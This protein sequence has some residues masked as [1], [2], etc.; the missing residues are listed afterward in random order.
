MSVG[1]VHPQVLF[2]AARAHQEVSREEPLFFIYGKE[3]EDRLVCAK[4]NGNVLNVRN[5]ENEFEPKPQTK[6]IKLPPGL[7]IRSFIR[8]PEHAG[9]VVV[10]NG[11]PLLLRPRKYYLE[12]YKEKVS[13]PEYA[14]IPDD[15]E[16]STSVFFPSLPGIPLQE[17]PELPFRRL[18]PGEKPPNYLEGEEP[19]YEEC[20]PLDPLEKQ[21]DSLE[22]QGTIRRK[23]VEPIEPITVR[24]GDLLHTTV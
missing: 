20:T 13:E 4:V 19:F 21:V 16:R 14:E 7:F 10:T 1:S 18:P 6:K 9:V 23:P 12:E 8:L 22:K 3:G 15:D 11:K 5:I 2:D 17:A 24:V